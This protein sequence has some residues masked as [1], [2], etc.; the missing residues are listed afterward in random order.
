[1]IFAAVFFVICKLL[2]IIRLPQ[3]TLGETIVSAFFF[4]I[5]IIRL[6]QTPLGE[7]IDFALFFIIIIIFSD[8]FYG[9]EKN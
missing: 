1:M 2:L 7:T 5:I 3:T 8:W 9:L 4:I 6:P